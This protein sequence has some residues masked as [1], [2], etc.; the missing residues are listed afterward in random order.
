MNTKFFRT[1]ITYIIFFVVIII[2]LHIFFRVY[3]LEISKA[4]VHGP[5]IESFD[6]N[7]PK[8]R[9]IDKTKFGNVTNYSG[10]GTGL[11]QINNWRDP[12]SLNNYFLFQPILKSNNYKNITSI[13]GITINLFTDHFTTIWDPETDSFKSEFLNAM[14]GDI[15][16]QYYISKKSVDPEYYF[17]FLFLVQIFDKTPDI[18]L[19]EDVFEEYFQKAKDICLMICKNLNYDSVLVPKFSSKRQNIRDY[20]DWIFFVIVKHKST[21]IHGNLST[22]TNA[23]QEYSAT[24]THISTHIK[25]AKAGIDTISSSSQYKKSPHT[26]NHS[27]INSD[28]ILSRFNPISNGIPYHI[29]MIPSNIT[30]SSYISGVTVNK[31]GLLFIGCTDSMLSNDESNRLKIKDDDYISQLSPE[32]KYL[33]NHTKHLNIKESPNYRVSTISNQEA[34]PDSPW[35]MSFQYNYDNGEIDFIDN[36]TPTDSGV[37]YGYI[38]KYGRDFTYRITDHIKGEDTPDS[39]GITLDGNGFGVN[40][41]NPISNTYFPKKLKNNYWILPMHFVIQSKIENITYYKT[42]I[43]WNPN[44]NQDNKYSIKI[45]ITDN[46]NDDTDVTIDYMRGDSKIATIF[47][48]KDYGTDGINLTSKDLVANHSWDASIK[49]GILD[50]SKVL[51]VN[52]GNNQYVMDSGQRI[53]FW[54]DMH[55]TMHI[56]VSLSRKPDSRESVLTTAYTIYKNRFLDA[57]TLQSNNIFLNN[58]NFSG[59]PFTASAGIMSMLMFSEVILDSN[60]DDPITRLMSNQDNDSTTDFQLFFKSQDIDNKWARYGEDIDID[61]NNCN[62]WFK[63]SNIYESSINIGSDSPFPTI[64]NDT[65]SLIQIS[66][67]GNNINL[68]TALDKCSSLQECYGVTCQAT[69][70]EDGTSNQCKLWRKDGIQKN[71]HANAGILDFNKR[72]AYYKVCYSRD[73]VKVKDAGFFGDENANYF[74]TTALTVI[75]GGDLPATQNLT[76]GEQ[77]SVTKYVNITPEII[78]KYYIEKYNDYLINPNNPNNWYSVINNNDNKKKTYQ[79]SI[80]DKINIYMDKKKIPD[81]YMDKIKIPFYMYTNREMFIEELASQIN[82]NILRDEY[83]HPQTLTT[84]TIVG[85]SREINEIATLTDAIKNKNLIVNSNA[86]N[87]SSEGYAN[88]LDNQQHY[89]DD[90]KRIS[91]IIMKEVIYNIDT[92]DANYKQNNYREKNNFMNNVILSIILAIS[93]IILVN[94]IKK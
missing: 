84:A 43:D 25:N 45:N 18:P 55:A 15:K 26:A 4:Q 54:F 11:T 3:N 23:S 90:I 10:K 57:P 59:S 1:L 40:T 83:L 29:H 85:K 65:A 30:G 64:H 17:S 7:D 56:E 46:I 61:T 71:H 47:S 89:N 32:E 51:G 75:T 76:Y 88:I 44:S 87:T 86:I 63:H 53:R 41:P 69:N 6:I 67:D 24:S 74:S 91:D 22:M 27:N 35:S 79:D 28:S 37:N 77:E 94:A 13:E 70:S 48:I 93:G 58:Y 16:T 92:K 73:N 42:E 34:N 8:H 38:Q 50:N 68:N 39:V 33:A 66:D 12:N 82:S 62:T 9:I 14:L 52:G 21:I 20:Q 2:A 19:D 31:Y 72:D 78:K 81:T 60:T 5:M 80:L 49:D 36:D